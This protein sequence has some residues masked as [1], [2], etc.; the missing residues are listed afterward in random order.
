MHRQR[1]EVVKAAGGLA[2]YAALPAAGIAGA[3]TARAADP[4]DFDPRSIDEVIASLV[5]D[6]PVESAAIRITAPGVAEDGRVVSIGVTSDLPSTDRI[7][8]LVEKNPNRVVAS[9]TLPEGTAP[10]IQTRIKINGTSDVYA[11][12]RA[13]GRFFVAR[14]EV[15]VTVGGC[16]V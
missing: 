16:G 2:A 6:K 15:R 14:R 7:V 8:V 9:F 4:A 13:G 1:R 3:R 11:L 5:A 12:V 10:S